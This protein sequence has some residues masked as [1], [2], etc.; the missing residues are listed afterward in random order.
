MT[1]TTVSGG[2][3]SANCVEP[4]RSANMHVPTT[5]TPPSR[6]ASAVCASSW[7]TTSSGTKRA[8]VSRVRCR[9]KAAS[10]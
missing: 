8:K 6:G 5:R 3:D 2:S 4:R 9:S 1:S 7:S 10:T